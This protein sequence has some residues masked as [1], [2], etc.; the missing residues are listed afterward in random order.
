MIASAKLSVALFALACS[1]CASYSYAARGPGP[2]YQQLPIDRNTPVSTVEWSYLWGGISEQYS[3]IECIEKDSSG[4]CTRTKDPCD[5]KGVGLV[6]VHARW[7]SFALAL[8][9]LALVVPSRVT[10]YCSTSQAPDKGP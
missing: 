9:T 4:K 5:G 6:E 7:Y 8:V 3:P 10:A 1:G 2:N